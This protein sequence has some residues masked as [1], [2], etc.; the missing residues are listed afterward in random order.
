MKNNTSLLHNKDLFIS[1]YEIA[2]EVDKKTYIKS[3][4]E[5][6]DQQLT[7]M[8]LSDEYVRLYCDFYDRLFIVTQKM[9]N[10]A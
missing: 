8:T 7:Q 4:I 10:I 9:I 5:D 6:I 3:I 1:L 2:S